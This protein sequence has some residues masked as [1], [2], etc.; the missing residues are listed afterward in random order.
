MKKIF[1]L[2]LL[3][4]SVA[5]CRTLHRESAP[6]T[7][8]ASKVELT[9]PLRSGPVSLGGSLKMRSGERILLSVLMPVFRTEVGRLEITP[10]TILLVDRLNRRYV[11]V[12]REAVQP[13]LPDGVSFQTLEKLLLKAAEP[14]GRREL[15]GRELGIPSLE[16]ASLRLYDFSHTPF[17]LPPTGLSARYQPVSVDEL[18]QLLKTLLNS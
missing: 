4:L 5:A 18:L 6:V 9:V 13:Y 14:D 10:D 12:S 1:L 17:E 3:V 2:C 11:Q 7:C 16:E 15:S 8:L